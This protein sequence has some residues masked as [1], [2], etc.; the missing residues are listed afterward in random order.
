MVDEDTRI[1]TSRGRE[2]LTLRMPIVSDAQLVF[3][4][5]PE[6]GSVR[7][8]AKGFSQ[9]YDFHYESYEEY[10]WGYPVTLAPSRAL[11]YLRYMVAILA[12]VAVG[13]LALVLW[14]LGRRI[15]ERIN[16]RLVDRLFIVVLL[17]IAVWFLYYMSISST[18]R[19][20]A[21]LKFYGYDAA[22]FKTVS[23]A[24][25]NGLLPY[26]DITEN[27]GPIMFFIYMMGAKLNETW[28][29]FSIQCIALW[30]SL[31]FSYKIGKLFAGIPKGIL[32]SLA[33]LFFFSFVID[34]GALTEDF[35]LPLLMAS[36][37]YA[38]RYIKNVKQDPVHPAY[39]SILY[40]VTFGVSLD[41]RVTNYVEIACYIFCI[42]I[43]L[44][45][46]KKFKNLL[47]NMVLFILG[48]LIV[49]LPFWTYFALHGALYDMLYGTFIFNVSYA[50]AASGIQTAEEWRTMALYLAPTIACV[51]LALEKKGL[52]RAGVL[53]AALATIAVMH[54]CRLYPH[55]YIVHLTMVPICVSWFLCEPS[56]RGVD[57]S[58][59][60]YKY[61]YSLLAVV[62]LLYVAFEVNQ[63]AEGRKYWIETLH[64]STEKSEYTR[65]SEE[66][67][68]QIPESERNM[69]IAYNAPPDW[70]LVTDVTPCFRYCNGQD[71][72]G[73]VTPEAGEEILE[74][75][76]SLQPK[77]IVVYGGIGNQEI[78][79][80]VQENYDMVDEEYMS[81]VDASMMLYRRK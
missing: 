50:E 15:S 74:Y 53:M 60:R 64:M 31:V 8:T 6:E 69:T 58:C 17:P 30:I 57:R 41:F 25:A 43:Y 33:T 1:Y 80:V 34:E 45:G 13:A 81:S 26:R 7:I 55:Y 67:V 36:S 73:A 4:V 71:W 28:G 20:P 79:S 77:W 78:N 44:F 75:F 10:G 46:K 59:R 21:W 32:S 9:T 11:E 62:V 65:V 49:L 35:N 12:G 29:L 22:V 72:R 47:Q 38:L 48:T 23:R 52:M 61:A 40:G 3:V 42:S 54:T 68:A 70:Y 39:V 18:P 56:G 66:M 76:S 27:K 19:V 2:P 24:W 51:F 14:S 5:G 37:Y 16:W 63:S